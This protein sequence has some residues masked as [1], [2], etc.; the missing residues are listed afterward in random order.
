MYVS[1]FDALIQGSSILLPSKRLETVR[2][3]N[4]SLVLFTGFYFI[5]VVAAPRPGLLN[6]IYDRL[7]DMHPN[8]THENK[9]QIRWSKESVA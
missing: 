5:E 3:D 6:W 4:A 1:F 9:R 8:S 2:L 7:E